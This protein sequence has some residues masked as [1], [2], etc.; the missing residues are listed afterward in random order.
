MFSLI[1]FHIKIMK[2]DLGINMTSKNKKGRS[3]ELPTLDQVLLVEDVLLNMDESLISLSHLKKKVSRKLKDT[4]LTTILD[5]LESKN[6]IVIAS[7]G[8][9]W[10]HNTN[11]RLRKAIDKGLCI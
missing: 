6:K 7:Q 1:G 2:K 9:T 4:T 10:I 11:P 3:E 8:I 5:Y